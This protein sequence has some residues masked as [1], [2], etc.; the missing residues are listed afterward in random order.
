VTL[1]LLRRSFLT[2]VG[3]AAAGLAVGSFAREAHAAPATPKPIDQ[4]AHDAAAAKGEGLRPNLFVHVAPD[5]V[6]TIACA[7]SEMGQGVRS[8]LPALIADEMGADL[9]RIKIVQADG[10]AAYGDQNTDGS[11]SVRGMYDELRRVGAAA[12]VLLVAAAAAR[13]RVR[14]DSCDARGGAVVH[15]A[16]GRSLRFGELA[17]DAAKLPLPAPG[18][19]ALRPASQLRFAGTAL[20]LVD[21]PDIVTGRAVFGADVKLPGMLTAVV[22]RPPVPGGRVAS[23]DP[24][25][26]LAVPGVKRVVLLP[27]AQKPFAFHPLGGVAVVADTTWA[28]LRGRAALDVKWEAGDN[29]AYDSRAYRDELVRALASPGHAL[30][31]RGDVDGALASAPRRFAAT[32]YAPHLAHA[33]MEPP[34]AVAKVEAGKCEVWTSTQNPQDAR[35][36]VA[37]AL[38]LAEGDVT[39]HVTLLGGGFG[40]KSKPDYV[41]EAALVAREVGAPVRLQWSR[42]DDLR[43]DYYHTVSAQ[44]LVAGIDGA[45]KLVAWRHR[46]AFP[47][48][49]STFGDETFGGEGELGQGVLDLPLAI[50]NVRAESCEARAHARIGWF[51]SVANVYHAFAVQSFADELAHELGRDPLDMR[52]DLLGPPRIVTTTELGVK[53]LG[54]YGQPV[55]EHPVDTAR[56][57]R[58]LE[59]VAE[60]SGWRDRKAR[61][62]AL[63]IAVHRSF[64]TYVAVVVSA[65]RLPGGRVHAD[66]AWICADAG[67]I[68][69]LERVRSQLEG[70]VIFGLSLAL[71]G[72][73][74]M[75]DGATEQA[76]FRDYRLMRIKEAPRAIH[77]DVVRSDAP[78]G[79]I[80]EPGVPPVAP[81]MANAVFALTGRR[82]R[83]LPIAHAMA[84]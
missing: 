82:V 75:K 83:D 66:E 17:K 80:G 25:S 7:R 59:R 29:G 9:A 31:D 18:A 65:S 23:H 71:Y 49:G 76:N 19:I 55:S 6:V 38:G 33:P 50:P 57:R 3:L 34:C 52:L 39:V 32:Y 42:E 79:G 81:A 51:R 61:G 30:R 1:R 62:R 54:N 69:N 63:G 58:V 15:A 40:R 36:E 44:E 13:W 43:H 4:A 41:V 26:A 70:A 78:P 45:G 24:R 27:A 60:A 72:E 5:D 68:V 46:T 37:K 47:P 84:V 67:T 11:H 8:S 2:G 22:A 35:E 73:I 56:H 21:G 48:I 12:R 10:D 74:T 16:S 28:A 77:V 20:P 53:R 14:E 64:L